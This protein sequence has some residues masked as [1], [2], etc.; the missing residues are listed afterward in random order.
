MFDSQVRWS[1]ITGHEFGLILDAANRTII[2]FMPYDPDRV[3]RRR[4]YRKISHIKVLK[5]CFNTDLMTAKQ[6]VDLAIKFWDNQNPA[7]DDDALDLLRK[8]LTG[9]PAPF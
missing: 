4:G 8:K 5:A 6:A 3:E 1:T 7:T 9:E 2:D